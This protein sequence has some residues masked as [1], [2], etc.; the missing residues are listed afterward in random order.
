[1]DRRVGR[2]EASKRH[3]N[4]T[5]RRRRGRR[6]HDEGAPDS[7]P[8][9]VDIVSALAL[10]VSV[11]VAR[12]R[13]TVAELCD[14]AV[15]DVVE[16]AAPVSA[17]VTLLADSVPFASGELVDVDGRFGVRVTSVGEDAL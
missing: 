1:M 9:A 3:G 14:L 5:T 15:G 17:A 6:H 8:D 12:R 7:Q 4:D 13:M 10:T 16:M 11:E 2:S